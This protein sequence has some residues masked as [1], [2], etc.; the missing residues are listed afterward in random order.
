MK[1]NTRNKWSRIK[2][3][4]GNMEGLRQRCVVLEELLEAA[5]AG[6]ETLHRQGDLHNRRQWRD[7]NCT[8]LKIVLGS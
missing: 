3:D 7:K 1:E 4:A 5:I 8:D 6:Q 2:E